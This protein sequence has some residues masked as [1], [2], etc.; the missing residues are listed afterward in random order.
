MG[1]TDNAQ[2]GG[3]VVAVVAGQPVTVVEQ[4]ARL[5]GDLDLP[6]VCANVDVNRYLVSSY[7]D[8]TVV[9][10]PY[11]PDLPDVEEET[12]DPELEAH[13]REVLGPI[14]VRYSLEQLAGD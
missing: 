14:G 3:I 5:A 8:G 2:R 6:L 12:F 9:A 13:L 11:D 7:V 10:L 1:G 4:A